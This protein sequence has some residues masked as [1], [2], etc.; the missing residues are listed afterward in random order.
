VIWP[1]LAL[2]LLSA[3]PAEVTLK[4]ARYVMGTVFEITVRDTDRAKAERAIE[5]AFAAI[6]RSDEILSHY[7]DDSDLSRVNRARV[8]KWVAVDGELLELLDRSLALSKASAGSFAVTV[9]PLVELWKH[10]ESQGAEP[11]E[12]EIRSALARAASELIEVCPSGRVRRLAEGVRIEFGAIGKGWAV[13]RAAAALRAE[14]IGDALINAGSSTLL[15]IGD[16]GGR[17]WPV[18]VRGV[19]DVEFLLRNEAISTS[20]GNER[21]YEI[22]GRRFSHILDPRSGWPAA[23]MDSVSIAAPT[24]TEADALSTAAYVLGMEEG[25]HLL[26]RLGRRGY[27]KAADGSREWI[28]WKWPGEK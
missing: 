14:S 10:A 23:G 15:V 18:E 6:R 11:A 3:G 24:A 21:Y 17:G 7:R 5:R 28:S 9:G 20:A 19:E 22:G 16:G 8:G 25:T 2:I 4:R 1:V 12:P 27:L 13:D 26:W